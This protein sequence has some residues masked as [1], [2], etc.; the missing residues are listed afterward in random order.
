VSL[1]RRV[2]PAPTD[3]RGIGTYLDPAIPSNAELYSSAAGVRVTT[4]NALRHK[5]V[6][7]CV[8]LICDDLAALPIDSYQRRRGGRA[9]EVDS[10][11]LVA[12]PW[13]ADDSGEW[14]FAFIASLLLRGQTVAVKGGIDRAGWP[15]MLEL[16]HPSD[17]QVRLV[18]GRKVWRI[19]GVEVP[20]EMVVHVR[21]FTWPGFVEGLSP[22]RYHAMTMGLGLAAQ[23]YAAGWFEDGGHPS[24]LLHT[25]QDVDSPTAAAVKSRWRQAVKDG[26][27]V[28]IGKGL[29]WAQVQVSPNE[30]QFLET[31]DA[32]DVDVARIF[33]VFPEMIGAATKGSNITYANVEQRQLA[34]QQHTLLP[35][36]RRLERMWNRLTPP[37]MFHR[38]N[39]DAA[40]RVDLKS[41][42]EAHG[43]A[44]RDGWASPDER[45]ELEDLEPIPGGDGG[46]FLWPPRATSNAVRDDG[47]S[48][49][50][51]A[52]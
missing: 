5:A 15:T 9:V 38:F 37:E 21:G 16:I 49:E 48:P 10:P 29:K 46:R 50:E 2:V 44:I 27:P 31:L 35:W 40:V 17:A 14:V 41:R 30:S 11:K 3:A 32:S 43:M 52:A 12:D 18:N 24:S 36:A 8:R 20:N 34:H 39:F 45:R 4:T 51:G 1:L 23:D 19:N 22:I 42:Y 25:E 26:G 13:P 6:W 33:G 28:V 47:G 7:A